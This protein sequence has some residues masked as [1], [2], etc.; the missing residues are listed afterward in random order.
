MKRYFSTCKSSKAEPLVSQVDDISIY[1]ILIRK[2]QTKVALYGLGSVR[3]ERLNRMFTQK[4]VKFVRPVSEKSEWFNVFVLHQNRDNRG[5]GAKNC[6]HESMI[7]EFMD[8]VVWGHEHE[9]EIEAV[10]SLKGRF[11]VSQ[12]GSS[13]ATSLVEGESKRKHVGILEI[14]DDQFRMTS[15]ALKNV[16]PFVMDDVSLGEVEG[17]DPDDTHVEQKLKEYLVEK[18]RANGRLSIWN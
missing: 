15:V 13:V 10:D 11:H 5:R 6:I 4:K 9:C 2:G 1:P 12:P 7:P 3:D 18:V 17:L 14:K 8:F 16:R